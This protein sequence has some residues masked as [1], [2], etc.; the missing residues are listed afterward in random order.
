M[1]NVIRLMAAA[2]L[3]WSPTAL[4]AQQPATG[5]Q[6]QQRQPNSSDYILGAG[7]VVEVDVLGQADFKTRARI[8][9]DGTI[10]LPFVGNV[11]AQGDTPTSFAQKVAGALSGAGYFINPI[12]SVEVVSYASR[13]VIVLGA[14]GQPGLQ[15]VD[16]EYRIS[17]ILARA[18]GIGGTGANQVILT[19]ATGEEMRL[20]F[21]KIATG[22]GT[23][24]PMV[25]PG[26]KIYV[27][28]AAQFYIYGQI[29][30]PGAYPLK[31]EMS[32]RKAIAQSGGLGASGS[33]KRV[34][35]F[36]NGA[37]TKLALDEI[38]QPGDVIVIGERFF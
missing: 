13:Y 10:A 34:S 8:R 32:L 37:K 6:P 25:S 17:E 2:L 11:G 33:D 21:E 19:R 24:D 23:D 26:D 16:R 14:V 12:V 22:T 9:T 31:G 30:A 1:K 4:V 28:L 27:P 36:R 7:D 18:G 15:P 29:N 3:A 5:S 35:V 38:I 20:D